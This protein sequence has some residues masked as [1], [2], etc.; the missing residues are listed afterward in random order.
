MD[1]SN[2][3]EENREVFIPRDLVDYIVE[4]T[5]YPRKVVERVL[6]TERMYYLEQLLEP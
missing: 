6:E 4:H 5:G 1:D 2:S 3:R